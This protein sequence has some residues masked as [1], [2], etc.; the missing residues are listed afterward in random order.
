METMSRIEETLDKERE[1]AIKRKSTHGGRVSSDGNK[2]S[3]SARTESPLPSVRTRSADLHLSLPKPRAIGHCK[4]L[5]TASVVTWEQNSNASRMHI[6]GATTATTN[7]S[8]TAITRPSPA[9]GQYSHTQRA[10]P[11]PLPQYTHGSNIL[12]ASPTGHARSSAFP[13]H[14][15]FIPEARACSHETRDRSPIMLSTIATTEY[16]SLRRTGER[17]LRA[18][19]ETN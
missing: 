17:A 9:K 16:R 18:S 11:P 8:R 7:K 2:R 10:S 6:P 5:I 12:R 1:E 4:P 15:N 13:D 14:R 19:P 3:R